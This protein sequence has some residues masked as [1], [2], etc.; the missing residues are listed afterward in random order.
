MDTL[1]NMT[2]KDAKLFE[3]ISSFVI[4]NDFIFYE[5]DDVQHYKA[6]SFGNMLHLQDC[7][8]VN[9]ATLVKMLHW[10]GSMT[11]VVTYQGNALEIARDLN[12]EEVLKIPDVVLTTAGKELFSVIRGTDIVQMEYLQDFSR[13]LQSRNCQL[14][15][16][17]GTETLPDGQLKYRERIKIEPKIR[18]TR[19]YY[20]MSMDDKR[21]I[22]VAFPLKHVSLDSVHEKNVRHGH[23]STLHIWPARRPLAACRAALIAT[24]LPDP[25]EPE[26]RKEILERMAGKLDT[27][28]ERKNVGGRKI[29]KLKEQTV[30]GILHWK[31][32]AGDDLNWFK[33]E[34]R[35]AYDGRSPKVL[36]PFAGGGAIP[37]E[38][39][40]LGCEVTAMDINPVAWFILKCT[41]E[42]P[43]K[44][45]GQTH[46]LPAFTL[47]DREFMEAFLKA[48]GF[49]GTSL[50]SFLKR[51][52]HENY[53][54]VELGLPSDNDS[55][56]EADLAWHVRIWARSVL[57]RARRDLA[58]YYPVYSEFEPLEKGDGY[59][60]RSAATGGN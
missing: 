36:D 7:G 59:E 16:L 48:K 17:K 13:F 8:L 12:A 37:F 32:E 49:K 41:L 20:N 11:S 39:M 23:I 30:G 33:D 19:R 4:G 58:H 44:L 28:I 60:P 9:A 53:Q 57:N 47:E 31:R 38:A 56:L 15:Y 1:K 50:R 42:Y 10:Q 51:L 25:G 21:L 2:R 26:Q 3:D 29:E 46:P 24:L 22:E 40:R 18:T 34:I 43:Q 52:G 14:F 55:M 54:E 5:Y 35:K 27:K 6:I 45:A